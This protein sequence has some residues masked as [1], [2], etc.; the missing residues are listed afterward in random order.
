VSTNT[1]RR[2]LGLIL[3]LAPGVGGK[4]LVRI[5]ARLDLLGL[6]PD[7]FLKLSEASLIEEFG[8]RPASA[9]ALA[10]RLP[11]LQEACREVEER[12]D[13]LGVTLVTAA[14]ASY[15]ERLESFSSK[16]PPALFLYGNARLLRNRTFCVLSSRRTSLAGLDQIE[17]LAES[18]V[19]A[20]ETL[21]AGH[22]RPEYQRAAVVPLRWGSPRI[23]CL[24]RGLFQALGEDLSREPFRAARLWRYKFDPETDL[25]ISPCQ[26]AQGF[27]GVNNQVRDLLIAALSDRLDFVEAAPGGN[28]ER[29]A[30]LALQAG[31]TV[32]ISDRSDNYREL[33]EAGAQVVEA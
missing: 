5:L 26:P 2:R 19:L 21:V 12:L 14:D 17:A 1:S 13:A 9:A 23:V 18:G 33:R 11:G 22:D 20:G 27:V 24:D 28:M 4:S 7:E 15:P 30:R 10:A 8:L 25:A 29:L 3:S 16:S 31:R 6:S 32:R